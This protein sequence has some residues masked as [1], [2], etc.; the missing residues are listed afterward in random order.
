M[1]LVFVKENNGHRVTGIA[2]NLEEVKCI[3][4]HHNLVDHISHG[5]AYLMEGDIRLIRPETTPELLDIKNVIT[6]KSSY[7]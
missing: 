2:E 1:Y 5:K 7:Y 3:L 4:N 6:K